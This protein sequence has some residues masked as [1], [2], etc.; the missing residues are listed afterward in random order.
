MGR[1]R[2]G[3]RFIR[4]RR[5]F[6]T[7]GPLVLTLLWLQRPLAAPRVT[8]VEDSVRGVV[9]YAYDGDTIKLRLE[10]GE[11]KR[12]RLIGVNSPE[13]NA[14]RLDERLLAFL[15]KRFTH[16]ELVGKPVRLT[17]DREREDV[18]GRLLAY[19]WKDEATLFNETL[20]RSGFARAFLK[21]RFSPAIQR[22]LKAAEADARR[23]R[24]G[25]WRKEP[26][27]ISGPA[28]AS[29]LAG[30]VA[31]VRFLCARSYDRSHFRVL[32]PAETVFEVVMQEAT[33]AVVRRAGDFIGRTLVVTG[34]VETYR[35][36]PQIMVGLSCQIQVIQ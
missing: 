10:S 14:P 18:Y 8:A 6:A 27:P 30:H 12:V 3:L 31:A 32:A 26:Y 22:R 21:Y 16:S 33:V 23:E 29:S 36:R 7:L 34:L 25:L 19:V 17:F 11:E 28:E 9:T 13:Y 1:S 15:A 24:L 2:I 35:G 20:V 5:A 4:K